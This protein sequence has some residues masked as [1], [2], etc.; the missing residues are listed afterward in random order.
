MTQKPTVVQSNLSEIFESAGYPILPVAPAF[1]ALE[2]P[3]KDN[4]DEPA[5]NGKNPAY[6][7]GGGKPVLVKYLQ[8]ITRNPTAE[9]KDRWFA[10]TQ[11]RGVL[12][13]GNLIIIDLDRKHFKSQ[14]DCDKALSVIISIIPDCIVEKTISGGYHIPVFCESLPDFKN[15]S[16]KGTG[17]IGE[18]FK[19]GNPGF[20]VVSPSA[21]YEIVKF[22]SIPTI[23]SVADLGILPFKKVSIEQEQA[24]APTAQKA[25][26]KLETGEAIPN[27]LDLMSKKSKVASDDRSASLVSFAKESNGWVNFCTARGLGF[28]GSSESLI[29]QFA[30]DL[31][32]ESARIARIL[33]D[34]DLSKCQP[35]IYWSTSG[36]DEAVSQHYEKSTGKLR[37]QNQY[38]LA[39][40]NHD[41]IPAVMTKSGDWRLPDHAAFA[42]YIVAKF[43]DSIGKWNDDIYVRSHKTGLMSKHYTGLY[44]AGENLRLMITNQTRLTTIGDMSGEFS[45]PWLVGCESCLVARVRSFKPCDDRNLFPVKNGVLN[46][47]KG[48]LHTYDELALEGKYFVWQSEASFE[49]D[50]QCPNFSSWVEEWVK[51]EDQALLKAVMFGTLTGRFDLKFCVELIG[52]RDCGKSVLQRVMSTLFGGHQSG[53]VFSCDFKKLLNPEA[54]HATSNIVGRKLVLVSDTKGF[55]GSA[56]TFKQLTSGGDLL[57]SERKNKD[58]T[59]Y[60]F[61][62][63]LWTAGNDSLRFADDDDATRS[64]RLQI[65][66]LKT[67]PLER[68]ESLLDVRSTGLTGKFANELEG[69]LNWILSAKDTA[70]S[71]ITEAKKRASRNADLAKE[72]NYLL[73]WL[74][75]AVALLDGEFTQIGE[76]QNTMKGA[77]PTSLY[78]SYREY[79]ERVGAKAKG[80]NAFKKEILDTCNHY[81]DAVKVFDKR[82]D[83]KSVIF[84]LTLIQDQ[85]GK[86][87]PLAME[88]GTT[89]NGKPL[90]ESRDEPE[91]VSNESDTTYYE[92]I[93]R[94]QIQVGDEVTDQIS[95]RSGLKV[96]EISGNIIKLAELVGGSPFATRDRND[97]AHAKR[98]VKPF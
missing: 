10:K 19:E 2:Y 44:G 37:K 21:G 24:I 28:V 83:N 26:S 52:Q 65:H 42:S 60:V 46:I 34:V 30:S 79:C 66:F 7:N 53:A 84:G 57:E 96:T 55:V 63:V 90:S 59:N 16:I 74:E 88:K 32:V 45:N 39:G 98:L 23:S 67:V 85:Y 62:G 80:M 14:D 76:P 33:A 50:A 36:S 27:L 61:E 97:C 12:L 73:L 38:E 70:I 92:K 41:E 49:S 87:N 29:E 9:E 93:S 3:S 5:V 78:G 47:S 25:D 77:A 15:F 43:G 89:W 56:D 91:T 54:R 58:S 81:Q 18:I 95:R 86:I 75:D 35:A 64:R 71:T 20:V 8:F 68:Q 51:E 22:G 31:G 11:N 6:L 4:P 1:S 72:D 40:M 82:K 13:R 94:D 17:H 69:I 48:F